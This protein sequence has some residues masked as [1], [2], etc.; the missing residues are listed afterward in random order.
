[1]NMKSNDD[2]KSE[3]KESNE[4]ET[5]KTKVSMTM[6][7]LGVSFLLSGFIWLFGSILVFLG[8]I[9]D[10]LGV[11]ALFKGDVYLAVLFGFI[12]FL[13]LGL[14]S[15]IT[16]IVFF[17]SKKWSLSLSLA[18]SVMGIGVSTVL[19]T[20]HELFLLGF[21][22]LVGYTML[23]F[24]LLLAP[25]IKES[26]SQI[27]I[28]HV[29][30]ASQFSF[31]FIINATIIGSLIVGPLLPI[32]RF[33][34]MG[35]GTTGVPLCSVGSLA[36]CLSGN[37]WGLF[38]PI[39]VIGIL[40]LIGIFVGR[41]MCGWVCPIGFIQD[42]V[43]KVRTK[44]HLSSKEMSQKNHERLT[45]AKYAILFLFLL[46]AFSMGVSAL[47]HSE[48]GESFRSQFS[49]YPLIESGATPCETCP[50]PIM[51]NF[52]PDDVLLHGIQGTFVL[53][54]EAALRLFVFFGFFLG[55][56]VMGRFFCRYFCPS[57]AMISF[58]NKASMLT[59]NK[60]QSKC[61]KC[62]YCVRACPMRI[63]SLMD[64]DVDY[65]IRDRE[66]IRCLEC[67]DACPEKAL[68]LQFQ[69]KK[70]YNGGKEWWKKDT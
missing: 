65:E 31:L 52:M 22:V 18:A 66:C 57:G 51:G 11:N 39:A 36:R 27:S 48:A 26:S 64:E 14:T 24:F 47:G 54:A 45:T 23:L 21:I 28:K 70:I 46:L 56:I 41:G 5:K 68:A 55:A 42:I 4:K 40:M 32:L 43:T 1:M 34:H 3:P 19:I 59:L 30:F 10:S 12:A 49:D 20:L 58:F 17:K 15:I 6:Q 37:W 62:N 2:A 35:A 61:T 33:R 69:N 67:I 53:T 50:A 8:L 13:V 44:L 25:A 38:L 60:D 9:L 63:V 7:M 29:R 16:G